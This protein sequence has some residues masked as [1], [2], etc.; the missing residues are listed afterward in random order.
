MVPIIRGSST[1][2][3]HNVAYRVGKLTSKIS[4]HGQWLDCGCAEGGYS[5][6]LIT[7]GAD[8]VGGIDVEIDRLQTAHHQSSMAANFA[9]AASEALPF[10]NASFDGVWMNEVFEHVADERKTLTEVRRVLKPGG[11]FAL[12]S[13]NRWFPFEG[14]GAQIGA[15][16]IGKPV[17]ILPWLPYQLTKPFMHARNYW[18]GQLRAMIASAGFEVL[19][20]ESVMPVFERYPWLPEFVIGWYWCNLPQIERAPILRKFGVS[21]FILAR[22]PIVHQDS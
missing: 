16:N 11:Y 20:C 1:A 8:L 6:A 22:R 4:L 12:I 5:T 13:P 10:R 18:P 15:V 2:F 9:G 14:H 19:F 17:P 21:T 7:F 3:P